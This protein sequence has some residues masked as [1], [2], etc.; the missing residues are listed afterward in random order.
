MWFRKRGAHAA[1]LCYCCGDISPWHIRGIE[2]PS[3]KKDCIVGM[4]KK[5]PDRWLLWVLLLVVN[6]TIY[7]RIVTGTTWDVFL[8]MEYVLAGGK[9]SPGRITTK[10]HNQKP[11][12]LDRFGHCY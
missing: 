9:Y 12:A 3:G 5:D 4:I 10:D 2:E 7:E 11:I 8:G 1:T 6:V